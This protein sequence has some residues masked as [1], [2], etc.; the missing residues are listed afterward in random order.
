MDIERGRWIERER[1]VIIKL[2]KIVWKRTGKVIK[3]DFLSLSSSSLSLHPL[4][5]PSPIY[6]FI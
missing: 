6:S 3:P 2:M 5:L 1:G 4:P